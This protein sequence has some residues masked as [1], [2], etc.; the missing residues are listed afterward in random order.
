M[1]SLF[2]S[3]KKTLLT[4][5]LLAMLPAL[6]IIVYSG[7]E[8]RERTIR[9]TV[10]TGRDIVR[11]VAFAMRSVTESTLSMLVALEHLEEVQHMDPYG[12]RS[13][14]RAVIQQTSFYGNLA[15][16]DADGRVLASARPEN[17][18]EILARH[19]GA[20]QALQSGEAQ[21][22]DAWGGAA[23]GSGYLGFAYPVRGFSGAQAGPVKGVI[24]GGIRASAYGLKLPESA[25]PDGAVLL[26]VDGGGVSFLRHPDNGSTF[27]PADAAA[28]RRVFAETRDPQGELRLALPDSG[29]QLVLFRRLFSDDAS[30]PYMNVLLVMPEASVEMIGNQ[31]LVGNLLLLGFACIFALSFMHFLGEVTIINPI[32]ILLDTAR[33]LRRGDMAARANLPALRGEIGSLAETFNDMARDLEAREQERIQAM[34]VSD[35]NNIAK[36]EFLAAMS[37]AIRTPMNSVIGVSYLLMR[38]ELSP[39]QYSYINRIYTSANTLLGIIN[40]ILDFSNIE[41]GRF[42]IDRLP[43]EL[44]DV[45]TST[46]ALNAQKAQERG[47]DLRMSIAPSTPGHLLGDPLRLSQILTNLISNAVKFTEQGSIVVTCGPSE[48]GPPCAGQSST[49]SGGER[50]RLVFT[51]EDTGIGMTAEQ[52][53]RLFSSFS[54]ADDTISRR[55]GGSGLGLVISRQLVA[56]MEGDIDVESEYGRGTRMSFTACFGILPDHAG[57]MPEKARAGEPAVRPGVDGEVAGG[58]LRGMSVLLVE[59]NPVNQEIAAELLRGAGASVCLAGN[60]REALERLQRTGDPFTFVLMDVSMPVMDGYEAT[61]AIRSMPEHKDLPIIAMTAHALAEER[62]QCLA[63]GMNEH[64]A[65]PLN[66][67]AFFTTIAGCLNLSCPLGSG[68][69]TAAPPAPP[70]DA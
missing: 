10:A 51:V 28:M 37:H 17:E 57:L 48:G 67:D 31:L 12:A 20:R 4:V 22:G 70:K 64:I 23:G 29:R 32:K 14:F 13:V 62:A 54:Q 33:R 34:R 18:A 41:T 8:N 45:L 11:G 27:T 3:V 68:T 60:G 9:Q 52:V 53:Q 39:R 49:P 30:R 44:A 36:G 5:V 21:L 15:L 65:K 47:L 46:V 55:Y 1:L 24:V 26:L 43:F 61:R 58:M 40:D 38:M 59:D 50:R 6:C 66:I 69:A 2:G 25:L 63:A 42:T 19:P 56:L 7:L 35:D 16:L